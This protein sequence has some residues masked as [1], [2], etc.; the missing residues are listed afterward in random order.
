[1]VHLGAMVTAD[2]SV[3]LLPRFLAEKAAPGLA[4]LSPREAYAVDDLLVIWQRGETTEPVRQ[5]L[6]ALF[7][8]R[9]RHATT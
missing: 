2:H 5:M 3:A 7:S 9:G 1:M 4:V 8:T 6:D